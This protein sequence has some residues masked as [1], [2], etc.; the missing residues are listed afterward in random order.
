MLKP[1]KPRTERLPWI[2]AAVTGLVVIVIAGALAFQQKTRFAAVFATPQDCLRAFDDAT[3]RDMV[4]EALRIHFRAAP[5]YPEAATCELAF[6][7]GGC[8]DVPQGQRRLGRYVP[9]LVAILA[10]DTKSDDFSGIVPLYA[11][12]MSARLNDAA[13]RKVYFAGTEVGL[14]SSQRY[15]GAAITQVRDRAGKPITAEKLAHLR[16][17]RLA[18]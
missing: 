3:C 4:A 13:P 16:A 6:G 15:G 5:Q 1:R 11:G 8:M 18:R 14:M 9:T 17:G 12:Q 7:A 10:P 2:V